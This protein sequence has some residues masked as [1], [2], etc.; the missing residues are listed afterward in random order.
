MGKL[1]CDIVLSGGITS[2]N[3]YP[4]AIAKLAETYDFRSIGGSS[5]GA[6]AGAWT[7][8]AALAAKR[9]RDQFQTRIKNHPQELASVKDGKTLLARLFQPQPSTRRLFNVFMASIGRTSG[10]SKLMSVVVTLYTEYPLLALTGAACV[11]F[12]F[13]GMTIA[14]GTGWIRSILF[15]H[16][17]AGWAH[18]MLLGVCIVLSGLLAGI[19]SLL[20]TAGGV[21]RDI[22][23]RLP[24]NGFGLCSGSNK[25]IRNSCDVLPL[26][27]WL[28]DFLQGLV[29]RPLDQPLTFGDLWNNGGKEDAEREI[30]LE[31]MTT[32]ITRG[33]SHRLPFLEGSWGQLFF[34]EDDLIQLFPLSVVNWMKSHAQQARMRGVK[35]PEGCY[36]LPRPADLPVVF[37]ARMSAGFPFLLSAVPLYAARVTE[38]DEIFLEQCWFSDGGIVSNFPLHFFDAPV[39]SRPTFAINFVPDTVDAAEV[40]EIS[41]NLHRVSGLD[42]SNKDP[43]WDKVWMPEKNTDGI[44]SA[45]RFNTFT[46]VAGFLSA[47]ID[48]ARNWADAELMAMPAYRDRIVH[49]KFA[50][51]EGGLNLN[52]PPEVILRVS[53]RGERAAELLAARFDPEPGKDPK[54]GEPIKLTWDNH[55]WIRYRS[56]MAALEILARRFRTAWHDK[57]KPWRSYDQLLGRNHGENPNCY[58]LERPEQHDFAVS[59]TDEF[60]KFAALGKTKDQSFDRH[61]RSATGGSPWPKAVLRLMPPGSNDP[62]A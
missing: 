18:L 3:V 13:F 56:F 4:R 42:T 47:V 48:T 15:A 23:V 54:T 21:I 19:V 17:A 30:E 58:Q 44:T 57:D 40:H 51:N 22:F 52:M 61:L 25:G 20:A 7:A 43:K 33:V 62:K 60:V 50:S 26:T 55:R 8:A 41:G 36:G 9:G 37:G 59:A 28:H 16:G 10:L 49:V 46:G 32:N 6:L 24:K 11:L 1:Q 29:D 39:P 45:A 5:A 27:D 12:P 2:G 14:H 34:K 35:I 31:L 38:I 53:S